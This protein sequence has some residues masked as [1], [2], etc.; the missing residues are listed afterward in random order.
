MHLDLRGP[1]FAETIHRF[2]LDHLSD[3]EL[4]K[5]AYLVDEVGSLE[6]PAF[7][8]IAFLD[9]D[10]FRENMVSYLLSRLA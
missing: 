5:D 7:R 10:L 1:I 6:R 8:D 9:L 3:L 2:P 4:S